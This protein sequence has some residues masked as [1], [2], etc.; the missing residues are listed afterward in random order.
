MKSDKI[1]IS[2]SYIQIYQGDGYDLLTEQST[3]NLKDLPRV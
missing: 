2:I 1:D 3:K